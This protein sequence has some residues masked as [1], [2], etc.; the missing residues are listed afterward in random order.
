MKLHCTYLKEQVK[1]ESLNILKVSYLMFNVT[2]FYIILLV[3][4]PVRLISFGFIRKL[5]KPIINLQSK[6]SNYF[7]EKIIFTLYDYK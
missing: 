7:L 6:I 4:F 2:M 5:T 1:L 3:F